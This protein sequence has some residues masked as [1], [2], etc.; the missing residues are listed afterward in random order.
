MGS[1]VEREYR[2][3]VEQDALAVMATGE[4]VTEDEQI[5]INQ[6]VAP[7]DVQGLI[8]HLIELNI[9]AVL[10]GL[11]CFDG[12][13]YTLKIEQVLNSA[14]YTWWVEPPK[15]WEGLEKARRMMMGLAR[16]YGAE[17]G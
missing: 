9:P 13:T 1:Q 17:L 16:K 3:E 5:L 4:K 6:K 7:G 15:G 8:K 2:I 11:C 10:D 14:T 12:V